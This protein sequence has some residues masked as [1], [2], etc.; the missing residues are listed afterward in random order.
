MYHRRRLGHGFVGNG[1]RV[2]SGVRQKPGFE[3]DFSRHGARLNFWRVFTSGV[4]AGGILREVY[5][6]RTDS[7]PV[8]S[9]KVLT[10]I[11]Y[12]SLSKDYTTLYTTQGFEKLPPTI[13]SVNKIVATKHGCWSASKTTPSIVSTNCYHGNIRP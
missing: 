9:F 1:A 5:F 13:N 8:V 2:R 11:T 12:L 3:R 4:R 7:P 6:W 10:L